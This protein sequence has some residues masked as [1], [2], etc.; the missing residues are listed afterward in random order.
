MAARPDDRPRIR[1]WRP[2]VGGV[3]EVFHAR[4]TDHVYPMHA[5][6]CWTLLLV[7]TG[8]VRYE[9]HRHE[10]GALDGLVTLLPPQVPHNGRS[11][12]GN[13]FRK[14][15][16]YLEPGQLD[17]SL[18]GRAVDRPVFRDPGL[19]RGVDRLHTALSS[20]GAEDAAECALALVTDRLE[21]HLRARR[22]RPHDPSLAHRLRELLDSRIVEGCP[23]HEAGDVLHAHPAHLIRVFRR[24]FGMPPHEY[25]TSRRVDLAR[26]LLVAG[27]PASTAAA[28]AGFHD[29]SHLHRHFTRL[30]GTTPGRFARSGL[31]A[32]LVP[33][34][35][36]KQPSGGP[37]R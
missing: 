7:D 25:L 19:R 10:H 24:E 11:A 28:S 14:H 20:P 23:L 37:K 22:T 1:A 18:I 13:G 32:Y 6:A 34:A 29:Q 30:L 15:V 36:E 17:P 3:A 26:R 4:F 31:R 27:A 5:H 33:E 12:T 35:E 2:R 16:L 9:L 8:A 21:G